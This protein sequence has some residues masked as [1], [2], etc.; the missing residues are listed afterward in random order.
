MS[1]WILLRQRETLLLWLGQLAST[2]GD[3]LYAMAVLWLVL[4][5]TGSTKLMALVSLSE[6]VPFVLVG[7]FA[8]ALVDRLDRFRVMIWADVGRAVL[9]GVLPALYLSGHIQPWHFM[10]VG[11]G[12]GALE[13]LFVP[14]LQASLP[15]VEGGDRL[16]GLL[17]LMDTTD[18]LARVLGPGSAGVLL[19]LMP[20]VHFFSLNAVSFLA[21]AA[22]LAYVAR[23]A[24]TPAI[25][26]ATVRPPLRSELLGG[27]RWVLGD[28]VLGAAMSVRGLCNL[29]WAAF[30][31]G[32][33]LLV[34]QRFGAGIGAYGS[35]LGAYGV[36]NLAGNL[37]AGNM[38]LRGRLISV[39]CLSWALIG[40]GFVGFGLAPSIWWAVA[41]SAWMG[42]CAPLANVSMDTYIARIV[43]ADVLGRVYSLQ[44]MVVVGANSLGVVLAGWLLD[45]MDSGT[46]LSLAGGWMILTALGAL[47][48]VRAAG[49]AGRKAGLSGSV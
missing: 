21:S 3:R 43:R 30:A 39:Y 41:A 27:L 42:V 5:L 24:R 32:A 34:A 6:S 13:A 40:A 16:Q 23:R 45:G 22:S 17:G 33:P 4:E 35:I 20:A 48:R 7:L 14:S 44:R 26:A 10:A 8:G 9:V 2:L 25:A 12:L 49:I 36:G 28:P 38:D 19:A 47:A 15:A 1:Y 11:L 37:L 31:I 18:R 46:V 29:V